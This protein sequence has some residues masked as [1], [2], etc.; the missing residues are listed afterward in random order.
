MKR[1]H[2]W[3]VLT[4]LVLVV[5]VAVILGMNRQDAA[6]VLKEE[7]PAENDPVSTTVSAEEPAASP[8]QTAAS[9]SPVPEEEEEFEI[10]E[11]WGDDYSEVV[12]EFV[13]NLDEDEVIEFG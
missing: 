11:E 9:P 12:D 1:N 5:A 6:A 4:A 10:P 8:V 7:A 3:I 13:V 2:L